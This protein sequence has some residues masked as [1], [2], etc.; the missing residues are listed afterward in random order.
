MARP[1]RHAIRASRG[2]PV[3]DT[4]PVLEQRIDLKNAREVYHSLPLRATAR[5]AIKIG[6]MQLS[7]AIETALLARFL[8]QIRIDFLQQLV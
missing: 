3:S 2:A 5:F 7:V 1:A 4:G 6:T 8:G